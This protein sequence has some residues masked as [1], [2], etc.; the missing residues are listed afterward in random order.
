MNLQN[1][2]Y[3]GNPI[4]E[5][6][7]V[8]MTRTVTD[9]NGNTVATLKAEAYASQASIDYAEV[10]RTLLENTTAS[11][12]TATTV[13]KDRNLQVEASIAGTSYV[14]V[15]GVRQKA[16]QSPSTFKFLTEMGVLR[17]YAGYPL[18][19]SY[20]ISNTTQKAWQVQLDGESYE[21]SAN[22][23][24]MAAVLK[25]HATSDLTGSP[26]QGTATVVDSIIVPV[27]GVQKKYNFYEVSG[28]T[29]PYKWKAEDATSELYMY[30]D[31]RNV[32]AG[33]RI[34]S[35]SNWPYSV[36]SVVSS[37]PHTYG[38]LK[39]L[40][41]GIQQD[42]IRI[43][44]TPVPA[45]PFYV[46]WINNLGGWEYFMFACQQKEANQL[47]V[48]DTYEPYITAGRYGQRKAFH[49]E[50][51]RVVETSTGIIDRQTYESVSK[52]IYSPVIQLYDGSDWVEIQVRDGKTEVLAEQPTGELIMTFE[53]PTPQLN[54]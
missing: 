36:Y 20:L 29:H 12:G 21:S 3:L 32:A 8:D 5:T 18:T 28:G 7:T 39:L 44:E 17:H 23:A 35:G 52:L 19:V 41:A 15:R 49:K 34:Y 50:A 6:S 13:L 11:I 47:S 48:N 22:L 9:R 43:V 40:N 31:A 25:C 14:F 30:S 46:R 53:L 33:D 27:S 4:V 38:V 2:A 54:K 37:S 51:T 26:S 24:S 42:F 1:F 10:L 45:H 16:N